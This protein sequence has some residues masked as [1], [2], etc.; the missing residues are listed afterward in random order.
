V[1]NPFCAGRSLLPKTISFTWV[2]LSLIFLYAI[3]DKING[4]GLSLFWISH[5]PC[6][7]SRI[8]R[9]AQSRFFPLRSICNL[10]KVF[11]IPFSFIEATS[12]L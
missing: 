7:I 1:A 12:K 11:I 2:N 5:P 3:T 8:S 4:A 6:L 10:D 9:S